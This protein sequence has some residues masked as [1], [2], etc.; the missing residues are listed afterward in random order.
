M[1]KKILTVPESKV[2]DLAKRSKQAK[3]VLEELFPSLFYLEKEFCR[4]GDILSVSNKSDIYAVVNVCGWVQV[5]N[6]TR[7]EFWQTTL[8]KKATTNIITIREF[9]I[10]ANNLSTAEKDYKICYRP[11]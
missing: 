6:I 10:L 11:C 7:G 8:A 9:R 1:V 3:E 5:L 2:L 4:I